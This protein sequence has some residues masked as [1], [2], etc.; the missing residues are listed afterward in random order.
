MCVR[1]IFDVFLL[2]T[3]RL[4]L[5][6]IT[7]GSRTFSYVLC[8][9]YGP[10]LVSIRWWIAVGVSVVKMLGANDFVRDSLF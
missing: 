9:R 8:Q 3:S 6:R 1:D 7:A 10:V 4:D 2:M 5:K